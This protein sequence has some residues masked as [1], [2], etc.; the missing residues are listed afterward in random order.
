MSRPDAGLAQA[1]PLVFAGEVD[2]LRDRLA[3]VARG[4]ALLLQAGNGSGAAAGLSASA[5]RGTLQTL[6]QMSAVLTYAASVP[7]V[8]VGRIAG[9]YPAPRTGDPGLPTRT[10]QAAASTLN[11]VRAFTTGGEADLS[12]VHAWNREFV[13]ASPAGQRYEAVARGIDRALAFMKACGTDPAELRSVEFYAAHEVER[14]DYA[15]ALTRTD[16]RTGA[17]Y[18]T[19]GH[20][21][22]IGDGDRPPGEDHVGFAAR[23]ANPV[24]VR[25][26]PAATV[27]EALGYVDRLDP[28]R[29]PGRLT[30]ALQLGADRVRDLLPE[31][32]EKVTASGARPVWVTDPETS[33]GVPGFDDVLD[34]V[35]GFFEVHRSLGTHP[36]GIRTELTGDDVTRDRER[37]L[38]LAFR[39]AEFAR[40]REPG[41][42]SPGL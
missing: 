34:E 12:Q 29:E 38:D 16:S 26:G 15:A 39:V 37:S 17:P 30:F 21:V 19:S 33:S 36:G 11:L 25:L 4:E 14:L 7:V 28:D 9:H 24:A 23:I 32:V 41:A 42:P 10:Y 8:K 27:D 2:Q 3:A 31:L 22:R 18:A 20:L 40:S 35:R 5:V 6:L 13:T 1:P